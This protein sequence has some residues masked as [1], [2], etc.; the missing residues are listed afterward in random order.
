MKNTEVNEIIEISEWVD[1][2]G[3]SYTTTIS[4]Q[5]T[6]NTDPDM[7]DYSDFFSDD[8]ENYYEEYLDGIDYKVTVTLTD[9]DNADNVIKTF[10]FWISDLFEDEYAELSTED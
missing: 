6:N 5:P 7:F 4:N 8:L 3:F 1:G 9:L 10:D 2:S